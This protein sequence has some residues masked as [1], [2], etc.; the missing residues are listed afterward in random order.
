MTLGGNSIQNEILR[1]HSLGF[2]K[3]L[4]EDKTTKTNIIWATD[5][6]GERGRSYESNQEVQIELITGVH[7]DIIK[8]RA[9]KE[10]EHQAERTK[11]HAEVFTPLWICKQMNDITVE[12][13]TDNGL[14]GY[15][16]KSVD[17]G[18]KTDL[19]FYDIEKSFLLAGK[20]NWPLSKSVSPDARKGTN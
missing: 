17:S 7:S 15:I 4:L 19:K 1:T 8:N 13:Y 6:Y 5:A 11:Q 10:L 18:V 2:L 3:K 16:K 20:R 14:C 12:R 9:Q